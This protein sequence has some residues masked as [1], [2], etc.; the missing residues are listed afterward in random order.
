VSAD[1]GGRKGGRERERLLLVGSERGG[2]PPHRIWAPGDGE[3]LVVVRG[4]RGA[5]GGTGRQ[6]GASGGGQLASSPD[7]GAWRGSG[8]ERWWRE[9]ERAGDGV[10][11][12]RWRVSAL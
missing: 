5:G 4:R 9:G 11:R 12:E 10:A 2:Q 8:G 7:L 6:S 1:K 3:E